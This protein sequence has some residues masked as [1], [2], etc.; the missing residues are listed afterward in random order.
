MSPQATSEDRYLELLKR[1]LTRYRMEPFEPLPEPEGALRKWAYKVVDRA[2]AARGQQIVRYPPW[3]WTNR[4][5]G[6]GWPANAETMVG[7]KRL[8]NTQ[9]CVTDVIRQKVPGD[10]IECG[11]WRGGACILM[12]AFRLHTASKIE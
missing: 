10:L 11:A 12:R 9:Y 2:L 5:E 1:V 7:L 8:D 6:R 4:E 3:I